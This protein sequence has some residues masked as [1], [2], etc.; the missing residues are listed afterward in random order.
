MKLMNKREKQG[1]LYCGT[2]GET[3]G[4]SQEKLQRNY[5]PSMFLL[6]KNKS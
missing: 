5:L 4:P 3:L 2:K 1:H 6:I